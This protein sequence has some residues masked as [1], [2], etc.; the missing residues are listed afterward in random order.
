MSGVDSSKIRIIV[1]LGRTDLMDKVREFLR[2]AQSVLRHRH[3]LQ[4]G[5]AQ[6]LQRLVWVV[7]VVMLEPAIELA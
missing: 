6:V 2:Q 4:Q 1:I 7:G 3:T 5:H